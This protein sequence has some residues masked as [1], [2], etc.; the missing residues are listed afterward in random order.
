MARMPFRWRP[1]LNAYPTKELRALKF[2]SKEMCN[3]AI[4]LCWNGPNLYDMPRDYADGLTMV[5]PEEAVELFRGFHPE[6]SEVGNT[7]DLTPERYAFLRRF[8]SI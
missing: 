3:Q 4:H 8:H 7:S 1:S 5:V 6:V 2:P